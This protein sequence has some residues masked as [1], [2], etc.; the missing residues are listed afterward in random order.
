MNMVELNQVQKVF[1]NGVAISDITFHVRPGECVALCGGNGAGKSTVMK[2]LVGNLL[3]TSGEIKINGTPVRPQE[4]EFRRYIGYMPDHVVFPRTLT[5]KEILSFYAELSGESADKADHF[6]EQVGLTHAAKRKVGEYSKGMMQRLVLAQALLHS[7]PL[8]LLDEPTNGLDPFWMIEFK[9]MLLELKSQG[10]TILLSSHIM[11]DIEE[12]ADRVIIM[13]EGR[14]AA[15]DT[16]EH[17]IQQWS[18]QTNNFEDALMALLLAKRK[19][20]RKVV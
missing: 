3:P 12:L 20:V 1:G 9:R 19:E 14:I 17:I 13:D 10:K 6:I 18:P 15:H 16:I 11:R 4:M 2:M 7:P 8:L 5:G